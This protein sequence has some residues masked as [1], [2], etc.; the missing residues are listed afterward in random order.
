MRVYIAYDGVNWKG[1]LDEVQLFADAYDLAHFL[2]S[3]DLLKFK[4]I[5]EFVKRIHMLD[6]GGSVDYDDLTVF[7]G[8]VK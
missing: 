8:E 1:E 6:V 5:D 3:H 2:H 4:K 7:V